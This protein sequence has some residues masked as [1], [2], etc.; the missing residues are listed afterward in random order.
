MQNAIQFLVEKFGDQFRSVKDG[1]SLIIHC[2]PVPHLP[3]RALLSYSFAN[4]I[5]QERG[6]QKGMHKK[7]SAISP[8]RIG[9]V[10][11]GS[12]LFTG[13]AGSGENAHPETCLH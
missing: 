10:S 7:P 2:R 11:N 8:G 5:C 4:A 9:I 3:Y 13:E 6:A 1:S 12:P